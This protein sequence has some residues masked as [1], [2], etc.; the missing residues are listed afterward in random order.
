MNLSR[1]NTRRL[2]V[3]VTMGAIVALGLLLYGP[4]SGQDGRVLITQQIDE[5]QLVRL[6]GN[7]RPEAMIAA[8]D[9]GR[10]DDN[11]RMPQM[12][13]QLKRSPQLEAEFAQFT[14]SL[15]DKNSPNFRHWMLAAE[16]GEKFGVSQQDID[17]VSQW[18]QSHGFTVDGVQPN[19]MVIHFSGTAGNIREAFHTEIHNLEVRGQSHFANMSDP[20]IPGRS[21]PPWSGVVA[22]HDFKPRPATGA[23]P[24]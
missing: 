23:P 3:A 19:K 15:T 21:G 22:M 8:N 17:T 6:R 20:K 18:L 4:L 1:A 7:T 11:F 12:M 2:S 16:Q 14:E 5:S 24:D 9:R 13:L 10:V